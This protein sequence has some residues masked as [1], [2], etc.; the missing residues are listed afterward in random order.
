MPADPSSIDFLI[1]EPTVC[2]VKPTVEF[3]LVY[4][5]FVCPIAADLFFG[6]Y[7]P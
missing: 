2:F 4:Y 6:L 5:V 7:G 3:F 1:G